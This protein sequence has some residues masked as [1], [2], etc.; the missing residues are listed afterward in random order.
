MIGPLFPQRSFFGS[1]SSFGLAVENAGI[2]LKAR[3]VDLAPS[4]RL[5]AVEK[6]QNHVPDS[7]RSQVVRQLD[8]A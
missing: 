6:V 4:S 7:S 1:S 2:A 5:N 3:P 8:C